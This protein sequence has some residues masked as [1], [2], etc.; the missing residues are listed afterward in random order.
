MWNNYIRLGSPPA[1]FMQNYSF[2]RKSN[3]AH[4][5][6][7]IM[8]IHC[9]QKRG[10]NSSIIQAKRITTIPF[11]WNAVAVSSSDLIITVCFSFFFPLLRCLLI[12][13][14]GSWK[15]EKVVHYCHHMVQSGILLNQWILPG[16]LLNQWILP[17][18]VTVMEIWWLR[19]CFFFFLNA[20]NSAVIHQK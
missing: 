11:W 9:K 15:A 1:T 3:W 2:K 6:I 4:V 8:P 17:G 12:S 10:K 19:R 16:P 5:W 18:S 7:Q 20:G 13:F 14:I